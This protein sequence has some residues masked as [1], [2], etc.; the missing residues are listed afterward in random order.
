M[1]QD[2][3]LAPGFARRGEGGLNNR[4][5]NIFLCIR[6]QFSVETSP[7]DKKFFRNGGGGGGGERELLFPDEEATAPCPPPYGATPARISFNKGFFVTRISLPES[8][9]EYRAL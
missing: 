3:G 7:T 2:P 1:S 6:T 9:L 5:E 8:V 4:I